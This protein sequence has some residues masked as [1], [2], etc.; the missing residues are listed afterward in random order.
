MRWREAGGSTHAAEAPISSLS[1]LLSCEEGGEGEGP[2]GER[3]QGNAQYWGK[4]DHGQ[5]TKGGVAARGR[6]G[7]GEARHG[8]VGGDRG[9]LGGRG[10]ASPKFPAPRVFSYSKSPNLEVVSAFFTSMLSWRMQWEGD[11]GTW[12]LCWGRGRRAGG[13]L[14]RRA[15]PAP[16]PLG[17]IALGG[18]PRGLFVLTVG[19]VEDGLRRRR[20]ARRLGFCRRR[21]GLGLRGAVL[22][23]YHLCDRQL[24]I[25]VARAHGASSAASSAASDVPRGARGS[26]GGELAKLFR[27]RPRGTRGWIPAANAAA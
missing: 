8:W 7:D 5:E 27:V 16:A 9:G 11:E 17:H 24:V 14:R 20:G 10:L 4:G 15:A 26:S 3:A 22:L 23:G 6:L 13:G 21:G 1:S 12:V 19:L 18:A 25:G 2:A